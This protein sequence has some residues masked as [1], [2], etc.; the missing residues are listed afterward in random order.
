[1]KMKCEVCGKSRFPKQGLL[2]DGKFVC[3]GC[4]KANIKGERIK[5]GER[6]KQVRW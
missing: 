4:N 3:H 6:N 1:M 5:V 2:I